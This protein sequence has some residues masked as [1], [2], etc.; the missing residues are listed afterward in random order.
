MRRMVLLV[1]RQPRLTILP[2]R[3]IFS[4]STAVGSSGTTGGSKTL[5][6]GTSPGSSTTLPTSQS[7]RRLQREPPGP[8]GIPAA[9]WE[10]RHECPHCGELYR[11]EFEAWI[12]SA[13]WKRH[14]SHCKRTFCKLAHAKEH[15]CDTKY[16]CHRCGTMF[17]MRGDFCTPFRKRDRCI[18]M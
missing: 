2:L 6:L 18:V 15:L 12:H 3:S 17:C 7:T 1:P 8:Y 9:I 5:S 11:N 10:R 4:P 13:K 14:C 16:Y